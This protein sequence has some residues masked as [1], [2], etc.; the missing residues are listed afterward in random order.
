MLTMDD[1]NTVYL[2]LQERTIKNKKTESSKTE[3]LQTIKERENSS[4]YQP[5]REQ[6]KTSQDILE[7]LKK[8][9]H[10]KDWTNALNDLSSNNESQNSSLPSSL[11][12]KIKNQAQ[13][14]NGKSISFRPNA[15][16]SMVTED[17]INVSQKMLY[18]NDINQLPPPS[19]S[20]LNL[21]H[22]QQQIDNSLAIQKKDKAHARV[23]FDIEPELPK[24]NSQKQTAFQQDGSNEANFTRQQPMSHDNEDILS[25]ITRN[26]LKYEPK[27]AEYY[28]NVRSQKSDSDT[29]STIKYGGSDSL[30]LT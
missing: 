6:Y 4:D 18:Y 2:Y 19:N 15:K 24:K 20:K 29:P 14:E 1:A 16:A 21:S 23:Q 26:E 5:T 27:S 25:R 3:R 13:I 9:R 10:T 17:N 22:Q 7:Q 30:S 11:Y 8:K 28:K 12:E